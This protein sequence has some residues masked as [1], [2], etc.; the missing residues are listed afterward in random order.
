MLP[1]MEI[2]HTSEQTSGQIYVPRVNL[3]LLVVVLILVWSFR[4]SS[5][6]SHAYGISVFGTMVV[7]STLAAIVIRPGAAPVRIGD[8]AQLRTDALTRYGAVTRD[9]A[10]EAVEGI[11]VALRGADASTLVN[12]SRTS[13]GPGGD[14]RVSAVSAVSAHRRKTSPERVESSGIFPPTRISQRPLRRA[15]YPTLKNG[16][17]SSPAVAATGAISQAQAPAI[18][19]AGA[20]PTSQPI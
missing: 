10:G 16:A 9:G 14:S 7:S 19:S 12:V 5:S 13:P 6:L 8:V 20:I 2:R 1:R 17:E 15:T 4:T 3:L 18:P 11:V